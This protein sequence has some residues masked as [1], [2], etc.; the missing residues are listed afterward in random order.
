MLPDRYLTSELYRGILRNTLVPFAR[1]H[2][3]DNY[4]YQ[5]DN[6]T[7][8]C[9]WVVLDFL[10]QGNVTDWSILQDHQTATPYICNELGR[11]ITS[12]DNPPQNLGEL[13]QALLDKWAEYPAECLQCLVASLPRHLVVIITAR[14]GNTRYWPGIHKTTPTGSIM[15]KKVCLTRFIT[16]SIQWHLGMLMQPF[17]PISINVMTN[18]PKYTLNKIVHAVHKEHKS[19]QPA[20]V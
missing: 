16:I 13:C 17:S 10:Q 11:A 18:L 12:M 8:H 19:C 5:D 3:G 20:C 7:P 14:G 9:A 6:A 2:F 1:Q 15:Q 4:R